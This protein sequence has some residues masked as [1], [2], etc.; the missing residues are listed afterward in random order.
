M[1]SSPCITLS[2]TWWWIQQW[3]NTAPP[4]LTSICPPMI[5]AKEAQSK[6]ES[7]IYGFNAEQHCCVCG[8]AWPTLSASDWGNVKWQK[9]KGFPSYHFWPCVTTRTALEGEEDTGTMRN[10]SMW[11]C[12][13]FQHVTTLKITLYSSLTYNYRMA[14]SPPPRHPLTSPPHPCNDSP[15]RAA[16]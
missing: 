15:H 8:C 7:H 1:N 12:V 9:A 14:T 5:S 16:S 13:V 11:H 4:R 2:L 6:T 3:D 10:P